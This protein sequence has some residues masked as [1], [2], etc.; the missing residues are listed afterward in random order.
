VV[1]I[2]VLGLFAATL[3]CYAEPAWDDFVRAAGPAQ[4]G[5]RHY[6]F[7]LV[8]FH[9]QGRWASCGLE[10]AVLPCVDITRCY[11]VLIGAVAMVDALGAIATGL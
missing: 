9:W 7:G 5:W 10:S 11:A 2:A 3:L 8:Y 1:S 6:V 4:G